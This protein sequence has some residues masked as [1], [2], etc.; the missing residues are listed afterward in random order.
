MD[1]IFVCVVLGAVADAT[2]P[3]EAAPSIN[4]LQVEARA[5]IAVGHAVNRPQVLHNSSIRNVAE[6]I[7][8]RHVLLPSKRPQRKLDELKHQLKQLPQALPSKR[9]R[10]K[11]DD[12]KHQLEQLPQAIAAN[13][14][15]V[16]KKAVSKLHKPSTNKTHHLEVGDFH[17]SDIIDQLAALNSSVNQAEEVVDFVNDTAYVAMTQ[18]A[19]VLDAFEAIC[20]ALQM[21]LDAMNAVSKRDDVSSLAYI[22][23]TAYIDDSDDATRI[24]STTWVTDL[25]DIINN[26]GDDFET[27]ILEIPNI[28]TKSFGK[29]MPKLDAL[30][31]KS[32]EQLADAAEQVA[33]LQKAA[34]EL[35]KRNVTAKPGAHTTAK[36]A[37]RPQH[38]KH[39]AG[40]KLQKLQLMQVRATRTDAENVAKER[41]MDK[42]VSGK[43]RTKCAEAKLSIRRANASVNQFNEPMKSL[44]GTAQGVLD[45]VRLSATSALSFLNTTLLEAVTLKDTKI[46]HSLLKPIEQG[47]STLMEIKEEL[48]ATVTE[49]SPE[50]FKKT[51]DAKDSLAPISAVVDGLQ[52]AAEDACAYLTK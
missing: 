19:T 40:K 38:H 25:I 23:D 13:M 21:G 24:T 46:P 4:L 35:R 12:L 52:A 49:A 1:F 44:N 29:T 16:N 2:V 22:D 9:P 30:L 31:D 11:V 41:A 42:T 15:N 7:S 26:A 28:V 43:G 8:N 50:V 33:A 5:E 18:V 34:A 10:R 51:E 3:R 45:Q 37:V 14:V 47:L 48:H 36:G 17:M 6:G 39:D 27:K 20:P 32:Y